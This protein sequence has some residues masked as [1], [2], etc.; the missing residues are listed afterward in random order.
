MSP[1]GYGN[2]GG[3]GAFNQNPCG[4]QGSGY[5]SGQCRPWASGQGGYGSYGQY[6]GGYGGYGGSN[7]G[8]GNYGGSY[9]NLGGGAYGRGG[10]SGYGS[11]GRGIYGS[12]GA[13]GSGSHGFGTMESGMFGEEMLGSGWDSHDAAASTS[14]GQVGSTSLTHESGTFDRSS[15]NPNQ[16][17]Q[18]NER[19]AEGPQFQ[20][21]KPA[22]QQQQQQNFHNG[23]QQPASMVTYAGENLNQHESS[24]QTNGQFIVHNGHDLATGENGASN[25]QHQN[26]NRGHASGSGSQALLVAARQ[27]GIIPAIPSS[28]TTPAPEYVMIN[29]GSRRAAND[30]S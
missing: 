27:R 17:A 16:L 8:Y 11:Y 20:T 4:C 1:C 3:S 9:N 13:Y 29:Q 5:G 24:S 6:G 7:G 26:Q 30:E 12:G 28:T 19:F 22:G 25:N 18:W 21:F 15:E 23:H 10:M 14:S 2:Q